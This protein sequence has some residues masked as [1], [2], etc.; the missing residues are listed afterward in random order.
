MNEADREWDRQ[1]EHRATE[2]ELQAHFAGRRNALRCEKSLR[3]RVAGP[4]GRFNARLIDVSR[5]GALAVIVDRRFA[6]GEDLQQ[7]MLYTARV[8]HHF[9]EG[10]ELQVA[11]REVS[12]V[13]NIVRVKVDADQAR[14]PYQLGVHFRTELT[15]DECDRLGVEHAD[16]RNDECDND[17]SVADTL[18]RLLTS[19]TP[20]RNDGE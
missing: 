12:A 19:M 14:Y 5:S 18:D 8:W 11:A 4:H 15:A 9:P 20:V 1:Q 3:C 17:N 13:A 7:L 16:D 2:R 6:K 10:L